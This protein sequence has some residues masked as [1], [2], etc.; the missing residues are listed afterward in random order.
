MS[1]IKVLVVDDSAFMRQ[2]LKAILEL[3]RRLEVIDTARNGKEAVQKVKELRPDV[4][5][6]D[7]NM[8]I[9]DG[10]T[11]LAHI[12]AECPTP[13]VVVSSLTQEGALATF[14]AH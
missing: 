6:L 9:M 12:M 11:A 13:T 4:V 1:P 7:I 8:P 5:T 2:H 3:D 10:L 14:E